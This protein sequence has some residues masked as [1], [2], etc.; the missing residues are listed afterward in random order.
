VTAGLHP[1]D[2]LLANP[3]QVLAAPQCP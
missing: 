3:G 2:Q 1:G